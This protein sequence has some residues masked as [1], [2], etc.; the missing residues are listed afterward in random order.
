ME[1]NVT[2]DKEAIEQQVV[3][4]ILD[5]AI[6][7]EIEKA[8]DEAL[9]KPE[10]YDHNTLIVNAVREVVRDIINHSIAA[11][12]GENEKF[13]ERVRKLVEETTTDEVLRTIITHIYTRN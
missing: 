11:S 12:L 2:I 3:Q 7:Q 4:A 5:S 1:V 8:I 13:K 6:G 9:K 10:R